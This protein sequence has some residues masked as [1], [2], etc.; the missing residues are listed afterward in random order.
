MG[1]YSCKF[2][3]T[4]CCH[5]SPL[6]YP[7]LNFF[8]LFAVLIGWFP[9]LYPPNCWSILLYHLICYW[10]Y[11]VF[12][13]FHSSAMIGSFLY[14]PPLC[15]RFHWVPPFFWAWWASLWPFLWTLY[16]VN[17]LSVSTGFFW[18]SILFICLEHIPLPP[19]VV[20]SQWLF[21]WI[22]QN[23]KNSPGF[24]RVDLY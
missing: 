1:P 21:Q 10:F 19:H 5:R 4:W 12:F 24:I 14:F 2:W 11:L 18:S 16:Q 13:L 23:R 22:R 6:N 20:S 17:Y 9:F 3:Y 15:L 7:N 8:F